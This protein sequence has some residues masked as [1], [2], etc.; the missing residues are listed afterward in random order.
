MLRERR[1]LSIQ[2]FGF[3]FLILTKNI[4]AIEF[5]VHDR[6]DKK[7]L[8]R[9][10]VKL[11]KTPGVIGIPLPP[12][13]EHSLQLNHSYQWR[14]VVHCEPKDSSGD[15]LEAYG[16]VTRVKQSPNAWYDRVTN[17]AKRYLADPQNP[18]VKKAWT[19]MLKSVGLEGLAQEP[20]VSSVISNP[21]TLK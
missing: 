2:P 20:L 3:I 8:Y 6:D 11:T 4:N 12:K 1:L 14:L 13:P 15:N 19:E 17:L 9:T 18:E 5:S 16:W 10:S 7:T 21:L